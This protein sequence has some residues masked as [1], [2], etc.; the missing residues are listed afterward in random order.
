VIIALQHLSVG[1][2]SSSPERAILRRLTTGGMIAMNGARTRQA[3]FVK[4]SENA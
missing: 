2:L 3:L 4:H 1:S